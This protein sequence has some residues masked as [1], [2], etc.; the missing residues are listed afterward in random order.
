MKS[1][2]IGPSALFSSGRS[3]PVLQV[4]VYTTNSFPA[5]G[6]SRMVYQVAF[7]VRHEGGSLMVHG[8]EAIPYATRHPR[9]PSRREAIQIVWSTLQA[10]LARIAPRLRGVEPD[11]E[12]LHDNRQSGRDLPNLEP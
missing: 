1:G 12:P 5:G 8:R 10:D 9:L 4:K 6:N 2:H 11:W 3:I 7:L